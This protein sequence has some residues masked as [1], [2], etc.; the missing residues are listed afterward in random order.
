LYQF[1]RYQHCDNR[2]NYVD[3]KYEFPYG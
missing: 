1:W 3:I 2:Y